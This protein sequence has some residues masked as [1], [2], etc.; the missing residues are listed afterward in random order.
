MDAGTSTVTTLDATVMVTAGEPSTVAL[1]KLP[2][3]LRFGSEVVCALYIDMFGK[4]LYDIP[5]DLS[6]WVP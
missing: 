6:A 4:T 2:Q 3:N 1:V 5:K